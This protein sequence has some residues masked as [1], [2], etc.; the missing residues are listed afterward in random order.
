MCVF[1]NEN[2]LSFKETWMT[3][4]TFINEDSKELCCDD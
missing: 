1:S 3:G 2:L 4:L